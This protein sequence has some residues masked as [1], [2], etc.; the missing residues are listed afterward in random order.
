M[1]YKKIKKDM[2]ECKCEK[3]GHEWTSLKLPNACALCKQI[4]WN[5]PKKK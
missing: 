1:A 2:F 3:C 5:K 4:G